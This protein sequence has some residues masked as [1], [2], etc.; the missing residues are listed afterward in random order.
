M[1]TRLIFPRDRVNVVALNASTSI[2]IF[3]SGGVATL[4]A[5]ASGRNGKLRTFELL[6]YTGGKTNIPGWPYPIVFDLATMKRAPGMPIPALLDHES[7]QEVGHTQGVTIS[8]TRIT[9]KAITSAATPFRDKVVDSADDGFKWQLSVGAHAELDNMELIQPGR[10]MA[11]NG[12][13]LHGPFI[14]ARHSELR[15]ITFCSTGADVGGAVATLAAA[16]TASHGVP[17]MTFA[18]YL[19]SIGIT[20]ARSVSKEILDAH[21]IIWRSQNPT[22]NVVDDV[23]VDTNVTQ[24]PTNTNVTQAPTN[25][26]LAPVNTNV[27]Q[28]P[29]NVTQAPTLSTR[30]TLEIEGEQRIASIDTTIAR[31]TGEGFEIP[32]V[33]VG[34]SQVTLRAHALSNRWNSDQVELHVHRQRRPGPPSAGRA[35]V[36]GGRATILASLAGA[37][38][39]HINVP[40]DHNCFFTRESNVLLQASADLRAPVN[41]TIRQQWMDQATNWRGY[42]LTDLM[43]VAAQQD[44]VDLHA[45]GHPTSDTWLKAAFSTTAIQDMFTQSVTARMLMRYETMTSP[46]SM[47][48]TETDLPNFLLQERKRIEAGGSRLKKIINQG[49]AKEMTLSA[50]GEAYRAS[51]YANRFQFSEMDA[52]DQRFSVLEDAGNEMGEGCRQLVYDLIALV[53]IGNPVMANGRAFY[54]ATDLNFLSGRALNRANLEQAITAFKTQREGGRNLNLIPS[55]MLVSV[56]NDFTARELLAPSQLIGASTV[57]TDKNTLAG[58]IGTVIND[59]RIDNGFEDPTD[60]ADVPAM[61]AGVPGSYWLFDQRYPAVEMGFVAGHGRSPRLRRG[62]L[63]NGEYGVWMDCSMA[64]GCAPVRRASTSRRDI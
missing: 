58:Q 42:S 28:A 7:K 20:D 53:L 17:Q 18:A 56:T 54:N 57:R 29:T 50:T 13:T 44:G 52:I 25:V 1:N 48:V 59:A 62:E 63:T 37:M 35:R 32:N 31:L 12:Q 43:E 24:A 40:L 51:M 45:M 41:S 4:E 27:T 26:T 8:A 14:L 16:W 30:E 11:I 2:N 47:L 10:S 34:E 39:N 64:V 60:T 61:I 19:K 46:L 36:R 23:V 38:F 49:V 22:T 5:S 3:A 21:R 33:T 55:H 9:G 15:E 6:A